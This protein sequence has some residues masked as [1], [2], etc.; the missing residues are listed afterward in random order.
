MKKE[1]DDIDEIELSP[2]RIRAIRESLGLSQVDAGEL[3]GGGPRAFTKYESG[4]IK[5]SAAVLNLLKI[6]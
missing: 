5:P 4:A 1:S 2:E 3:I 6:L